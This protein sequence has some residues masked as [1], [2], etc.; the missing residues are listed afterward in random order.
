MRNTKPARLF[1]SVSFAVLA[2]AMPLGGA[3]RAQS[4]L[5]ATQTESMADQRIAACS[6]MLSS[7]RL[8]GKQEGI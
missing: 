5:C 3:A 6:S 2:M 8:R 1:A 4:H 7:G